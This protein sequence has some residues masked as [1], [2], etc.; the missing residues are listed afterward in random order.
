VVDDVKVDGV[1]QGAKTSYTFTNVTANHTIAATF[2]EGAPNGVLDPAF[3]SGGKVTTAIGSVYDMINSLALQK[4]GKIV[5]GG[6]S[7][8]EDSPYNT[9]FWRGALVRYD[10]NGTLD[11]SFGSGGKV[12]QSVANKTDSIH[13]VAIQS[14]GK[15]LAAGSTDYQYGQPIYGTL[16]RYHANGTLDTS[17]GAG[18]TGIMVIKHSSSTEYG[19]LGS[20]VVQ[21]DGKILTGGGAQVGANPAFLALLRFNS[22]GSLDTTF[23]GGTGKVM[24]QIYA[25]ANP[26]IG[27][28]LIRALA[29][30]P[31]GKIVAGGHAYNGTYV[32]PVLVR[33]NADG[34][35][36][37]AFGNG[38][39]IVTPLGYHNRIFAIALQ[40][41]GK[42]LAPTAYGPYMNIFRYNANGSPDTSFGAGGVV[43]V[44]NAQ[45]Y[46]VAFQPDGKIVVGGVNNLP[47]GEYHFSLWRLNPSGTWDSN[48]GTGGNVTTTIVAGKNDQAR[49]LVRQPDGKVVLGG[50]AANVA[51]GGPL[52]VGLGVFALA[53]YI[54]DISPSKSPVYLL[55][56]D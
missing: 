52:D 14:D 36:D 23:G 48:F 18:G 15:I 47:S 17:F 8:R 21:P 50:T 12:I 41:D 54:M 27:F 24:T 11:A 10:A 46:G 55:L 56:L 22:D 3:G 37:S 34:S 40:P 28:N 9:N 19:G 7:K 35:L 42:I 45:G 33:Y 25:T 5:A 39:K 49:A 44:A 53:R 38:G 51:S 1:S 43:K 13:G 6:M 30:Q 2:T 26:P 29:L 16:A 32:D 4:D 31:D 20:V